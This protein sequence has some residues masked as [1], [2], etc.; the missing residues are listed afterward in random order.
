MAERKRR[1]GSRATERRIALAVL[2]LV[3]GFGAG[4]VLPLLTA[5]SAQPPGMGPPHGR[6]H[7][8]PPF[9]RVLERHADRLGLDAETRTSIARLA[10]EGRAAAAPLHEELHALRAELHGLLDAEAPDE[11]AV[12]AHAERMGEVETELRKLRLLDL[13][14]IRALLTPAQRA[15][16]VAIHEERR[17]RRHGPAGPLPPP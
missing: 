1:S 6:R 14:R 11:T 7:G 4:L 13:L 3:L 12:L 9:H 15:E 2:V 16:L 5:A 10:E 17:A 8:P